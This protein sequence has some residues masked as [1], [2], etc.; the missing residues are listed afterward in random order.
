M[1]ETK[2]AFISKIDDD[3]IKIILKPD[4]R[5]SEQEY[6]SFYPIYQEM[7]NKD[8]DIKLFILIQSGARVERK[9]P[10]F[11]RNVYKL[12]YKKAEAYMI[13]SPVARMFLKLM[14]KIVGSKYPVRLFY[15]E[16]EAIQWLQSI[17]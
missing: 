11:F 3:T 8:K 12:D 1:V 17:P 10:D 9:L 15:S 5:V 7:L 13:I 6:K 2:S 14:M 4:A 16:T